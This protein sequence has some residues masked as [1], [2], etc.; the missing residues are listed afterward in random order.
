MTD[1]AS[2][3]W[4]VVGV[5]VT[6][7]GLVTAIV[8]PMLKLNTSITTLTTKMAQLIAIQEKNEKK[9]EGYD[10]ELEDHEIRITV[11]EGK[12]KGSD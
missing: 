1:I 4:I 2:L 6:L 7:I 5:I 11:L 12:N 10:N 9:H 3:E 8:T